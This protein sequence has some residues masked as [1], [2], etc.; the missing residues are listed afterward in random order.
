MLYETPNCKFLFAPNNNCPEGMAYN[1]LYP[2]ICNALPFLKKCSNPFP[3]PFTN[4][5]QPTLLLALAQPI[6]STINY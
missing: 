1:T 4:A 2:P 3:I 5:T 6:L